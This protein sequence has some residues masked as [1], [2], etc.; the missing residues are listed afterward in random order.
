MVESFVCPHCNVLAQMNILSNHY[1]EA[2]RMNFRVYYCENCRKH[3][4]RSIKRVRSGNIFSDEGLIHQYPSELEL[5]DDAVP[6][7]VSKLYKEG[8]RCINAEAPNGAMT[9]FRKALQV[10]C[11]KKGA[12]PSNEL[13]EQ[14]DSVLSKRVLELSTEIRKWGNI[15]AHLDR[16]VPDPTS[17]QAKQVKDFF[18]IIFADEYIIPAKIENSKKQREGTRS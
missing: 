5:V 6:N 7:E 15:G 9:C 16:I 13:W 11:I 14:I 18:E 8:I 2:M 17:E 3:I 1:D 10:I 12:N 4:F